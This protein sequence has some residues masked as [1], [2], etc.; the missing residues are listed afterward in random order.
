ME[1]IKCLYWSLR[2][3][4]HNASYS[5]FVKKNVPNRPHALSF[6]IVF[7]V[8]I[9]LIITYK[10][11]KKQIFI[12]LGMIKISKFKQKRR[13]KKEANVVNLTKIELYIL[14]KTITLVIEKKIQDSKIN[15]YIIL[16]KTID[17]HCN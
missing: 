11:R 4:F 3:Y 13:R 2:N 10:V 9:F 7:T 16:K 8:T 12:Y 1:R 17:M 14:K 6:N 5:S 15:N